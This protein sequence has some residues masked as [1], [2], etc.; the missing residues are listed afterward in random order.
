MV[1]SRRRLGD[2][3]ERVAAHRLEAAGMVIL[4]RNLCIDRNEVD[5]VVR[6]GAETVFVEVRTRRAVPGL[7]AE[8]VNPAKLR[9]VWACALAYCLRENINPEDTR[10]DVVAIDLDGAGRATAVEHFRGVEIAPAPE[11]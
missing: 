10:I 11:P 8:S 3:G 6:D 5:L 1:T 4:D 7:A 2:F 9:R